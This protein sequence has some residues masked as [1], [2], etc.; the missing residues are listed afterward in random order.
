MKEQRSAKSIRRFVLPVKSCT[1]ITRKYID[2][3]LSDNNYYK[4]E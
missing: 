3:Y 1:L 2:K 4:Y